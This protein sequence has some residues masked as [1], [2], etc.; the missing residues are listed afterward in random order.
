MSFLLD[1]CVI[2]ET[3][4]PRPNERVMRWFSSVSESDIFIP[5]VVFGELRDGVEELADGAK[6]RMLLRW[7][8]E[9]H[10]KYSDK[11]IPFDY[12][13][14]D[15]W[16][17]IFAQGRING[18]TPAVIDSQIAATAL[19]HGMALVTRNVRDM[20]GFGVEIVNP[21]DE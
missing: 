15:L 11:V 8:D 6:K 16:G 17:R 7:F 14:A 3:S 19:H 5:A 4:R 13:C 10:A 1:T 12:D 21:F 20:V 2:S 9:W 18:R